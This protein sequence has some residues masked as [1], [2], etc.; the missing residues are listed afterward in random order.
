MFNMESGEFERFNQL[1]D[2]VKDVQCMWFD[3]RYVRRSSEIAY[4]F[5]KWRLIL[6]LKEKI[7]IYPLT[8]VTNTFWNIAEISKK[9]DVR[10]S[11]EIRKFFNKYDPIKS[12]ETL[13][14]MQTPINRLQ[15]ITL[16]LTN[17]NGKSWHDSL[18]HNQGIRGFRKPIAINPNHSYLMDNSRILLGSPE[19]FQVWELTDSNT[20]KLYFQGFIPIPYNTSRRL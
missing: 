7:I 3:D 18:T 19:F 20:V 10:L 14:S 5:S 16:N 11:T 2:G 9:Q 15:G 12:P 1:S 4:T 8:E 13:P 6:V 17:D